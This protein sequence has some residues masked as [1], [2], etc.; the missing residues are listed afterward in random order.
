MCLSLDSDAVFECFGD[1]D[2]RGSALSTAGR[3][4]GARD[5]GDDQGQEEEGNREPEGKP[6]DDFLGTAFL[7]LGEYVQAAAGDSAGSTFGTAALEQR[8]NDDD[9]GHDDE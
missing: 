8:K 4:L 7:R 2:E 6:G 3:S 9:Q 1:R 5:N